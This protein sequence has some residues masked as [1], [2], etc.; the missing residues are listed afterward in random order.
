MPQKLAVCQSSLEVSSEVQPATWWS[1]KE[2]LCST[3]NCPCTLL[4]FPAS[5]WIVVTSCSSSRIPFQWIVQVSW[6]T[7]IHMAIHIALSRL[8]FFSLL[9][10]LLFLT[11]CCIEHSST[12]YWTGV[13]P[14]TVI[15]VRPRKQVCGAIMHEMSFEY[16]YSLLLIK[17]LVCRWFFNLFQMLI[18]L[19]VQTISLSCLKLCSCGYLEKIISECE[20]MSFCLGSY[21]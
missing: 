5:H 21:M 15:K 20:A 6:G 2:K 4:L 7:K 12:R 8:E 13:L 16:I 18:F 10:F 17:K 9:L 11:S 14:G 3:K 1:G 19:T